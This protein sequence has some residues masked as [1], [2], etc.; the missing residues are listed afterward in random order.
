[1]IHSNSAARIQL[2]IAFKGL[3]DEIDT[4][5]IAYSDL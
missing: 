1:M 3:E 4:K 5:M 2:W